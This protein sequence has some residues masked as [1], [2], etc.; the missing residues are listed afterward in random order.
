MSTI[1]FLPPSLEIV[2]TWAEE[3]REY[4]TLPV[5][6]ALVVGILVVDVGILYIL[7]LLVTHNPRPETESEK[8]YI[9]VTS[10][11]KQKGGIRLP[12]LLDEKVEPE[13]FMSVVVPAYN[14]E[15]RIEMMLDEAVEFLNQEF[16]KGSSGRK[17]VN[18]KANGYANGHANGHIDGEREKKKG[19][20]IIIVD[21]GSKDKT[22]EVVVEWMKKRV[23]KGEVEE[24]DLR[25][26]HLERNRGKGGA[27]A[28]GMRHIRGQYAVF[29]D[30]DGATK[31]SDLK[32]LLTR[33]QSI[34]SSRASPTTPSKTEYHG[35]SV[36][37]RAH[38][39]NSSAVV[40]RSWYRNLLMYGFHTF[41]HVIGIQ[42]IK[43]T[44][45]GFKLFTR[46]TARLVFWEGHCEGWIFDIECLLIAEEEKVGVEEVSVTW[47]EVE[48]TKMNL[49]KDSIRMA[50]DLVV[51]RAA[52]AV[53]VYGG[54]RRSWR[55]G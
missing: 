48:G 51:L 5:V 2:N 49:V 31:F 17:A 15:L 34:E 13:V 1:P 10:D 23:E 32:T 45:C 26:V 38:M 50:W 12:D 7:L 3:I 11:G 20:E 46:D 41:L 24:G 14:E 9:T 44:Q 40:A 30:A 39:V 37:S 16:P 29:A 52:Y 8:H 42:K 4:L 54:V 53:G 43:D 27:V 19:W 21:D 6:L 25:I 36:G 47:H 22:T 18:G 28:H 35:I 55:R 33:L